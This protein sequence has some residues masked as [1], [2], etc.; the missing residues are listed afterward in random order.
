[1]TI[2]GMHGGNR[3]SI[4][5]KIEVA[6]INRLERLEKYSVKA[7]ELCKSLKN[8]ERGNTNPVLWQ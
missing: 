2:I 8:I 6:I 1:M 7:S 3:L 4:Q 5:E